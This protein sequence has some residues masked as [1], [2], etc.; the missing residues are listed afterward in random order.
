MIDWFLMMSDIVELYLF[1]DWPVDI[2]IG[3]LLTSYCGFSDI[4]VTIKA[5]GPLVYSYCYIWFF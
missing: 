5:G 3:V 4:Q 1:S 2:Q